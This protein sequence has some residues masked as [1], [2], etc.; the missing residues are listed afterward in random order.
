MTLG[1]EIERQWLG[2]PE[3][4]RWRTHVILCRLNCPIQRET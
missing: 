3:P 4:T 1:F 2:V